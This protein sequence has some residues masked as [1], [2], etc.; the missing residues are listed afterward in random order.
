MSSGVGH[1][2]GSDPVLL[3]GWCRLVAAAPIGPLAWDLPYAMDAA[4]K[5]QKIKQ[6]MVMLPL[7]HQLKGKSFSLSPLSMRLSVAFP[8][9]PY[10][11]FS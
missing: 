8:K 7:F 6:G 5:R 10:M 4:L 11:A 1:R 9:M 2:L 3:W